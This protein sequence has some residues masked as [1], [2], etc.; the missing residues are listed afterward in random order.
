MA[1]ASCCLGRGGTGEEGAE[2]EDGGPMFSQ[3]CKN[4]GPARPAKRVAGSRFG[5]YTPLSQGVCDLNLGNVALSDVD[6]G[7]HDLDD[8]NTSYGAESPSAGWRQLP[9]VPTGWTMRVS[10]PSI[11]R[12]CVTKF[13]PNEALKLIACDANCFLAKGS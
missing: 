1:V 3:P 7:D 6:L 13:A 4:I 5:W 8:V 11:L 2:G 10:F 9:P 12:C